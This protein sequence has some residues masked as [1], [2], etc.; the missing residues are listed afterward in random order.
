MQPDA[1]VDSVQL[2]AG[3]IPFGHGAITHAAYDDF[4]AREAKLVGAVTTPTVS[5]G[6]PL[7][8]SRFA[9]DEEPGRR[10]PARTT[11]T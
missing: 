3:S 9:A 8:V 11:R 7:T 4:R 6:P 2:A 10:T 1:Y 5:A